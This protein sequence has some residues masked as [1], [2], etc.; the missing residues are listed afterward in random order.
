[1]RTGGEPTLRPDL[2]EIIYSARTMFDRV[3]LT[4]NR[5]RLNRISDVGVPCEALTALLIAVPAAGVPIGLPKYRRKQ[6]E[7]WRYPCITVS[8]ADVAI[9]HRRDPV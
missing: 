1:M 9:S 7:A 4:T 8:V 2:G 3:E 6:N 5:A